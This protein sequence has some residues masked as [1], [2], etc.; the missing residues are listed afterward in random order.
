MKTI[1]F[2][3]FGQELKRPFAVAEQCYDCAE[4]YDGCHA[5]PASKPWRCADY[6]QRLDVMPGTCGQMF[7]PS[8]MKGRKEPQELPTPERPARA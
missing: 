1:R 4:F 2:P 8:R 3:D 5:W 7:P 6:L